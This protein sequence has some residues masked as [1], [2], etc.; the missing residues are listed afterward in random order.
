MQL[1]ARKEGSKFNSFNAVRSAIVL[2]HCHNSTDECYYPC[3]YCVDVC[4]S[5]LEIVNVL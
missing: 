4:V 1:S 5:V 3:Q 2:K